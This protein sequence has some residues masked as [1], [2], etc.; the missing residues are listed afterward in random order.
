MFGSFLIG[1]G[2]AASTL[3]L[4]VDRP[5]AILGDNHPWQ[6]NYSIQI[7]GLLNGLYKM[8]QYWKH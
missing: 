6:E 8:E 7:G 5:I 4:A 3:S 2:A 1:V